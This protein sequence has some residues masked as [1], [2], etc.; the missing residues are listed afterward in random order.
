MSHPPLVSVVMGVYNGERS[1]GPTIDSIRSQTMTDWEFVIV[2]DASTDSSA[3]ILADF[4]KRDSRI[5]IFRQ[6][7]NQGLTKAL[8][9]GCCE[10]R[11]TYIARQDNGDYSLK[12]RLQKQWIFLE[13]NSDVVAVGSGIRRIGP[14]GEFLGDTTREL[15]PRSV[16]AMFLETGKSIVHAAAMIRRSALEDAGGYRCEFR[17]AQDIDLWYRLSDLGLI[18]ELSDVL[19]CISIDLRGISATSNGKQHRL[20][21]IARTCHAARRCGMAESVLLKQAEEISCEKTIKTSDSVSERRRRGEPNYFLG[22]E[23]FSHRNPGCRA[24]LVHSIR[25]RHR[26]PQAVAKYF[27]SFLTCSTEKSC[28][29]SHDATHH[30]NE[31]PIT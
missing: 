10:A 4:A 9:H 14:K 31:S 29:P 8:I 28:Q 24:Y 17:V 2:D 1:L 30:G 12:D 20:A 5:R 21:A 16:T 27:L 6:S 23:L 25:C 26:I 19:S 18:A 15:S 7:E 3:K 13:Q 22:S 11:G